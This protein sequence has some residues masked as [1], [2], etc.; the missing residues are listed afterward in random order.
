VS[1]DPAFEEKLTEIVG[2]S[3]DRRSG[4]WCTASTRRP[5]SRMLDRTQQS[6]PMIRGRRQR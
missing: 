2:L 1:T 3:I 6:L 5:R 4:R